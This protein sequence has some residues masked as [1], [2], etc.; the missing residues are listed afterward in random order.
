MLTAVF[1]LGW[2]LRVCAWLATGT[3]D[4]IFRGLIQASA[5]LPGPHKLIRLPRLIFRLNF[6][7]EGKVFNFDNHRH[8]Y[9][10]LLKV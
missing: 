1:A 4:L 6:D 9:R 8:D 2:L 10:S 5:M 3:G 7:D